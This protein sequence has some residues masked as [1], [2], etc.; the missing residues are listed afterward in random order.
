M[1]GTRV[2]GATWR[3]PAPLG[4]DGRIARGPLRGAPISPDSTPIPGDVSVAIA[5]RGPRARHRPRQPPLPAAPRSCGSP[6]GGTSE[7]SC[8]W[9]IRSGSSRQT[10][11]EYANVT[12]T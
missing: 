2:L 9:G 4:Q 11:Y 8:A 5:A 7:G 1:T 6:V 12:A 3:V 10:T